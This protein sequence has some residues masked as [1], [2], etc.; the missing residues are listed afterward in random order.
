M[1]SRGRCRIAA[2]GTK[3]KPWEQKEVDLDAIT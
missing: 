2:I 3:S 1:K